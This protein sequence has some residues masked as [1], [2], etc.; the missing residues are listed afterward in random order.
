M[1]RAKLFLGGWVLA[2]GVL[3]NSEAMAQFGV[4][5]WYNPYGYGYGFGGGTVEG[6]ALMGMSTVIRSAGEYNLYT[7]EAGVNYEEARS[8]YLDNRRKWTQQ[9]FQMRETR[10]A[11]DAQKKE[12]ARQSRDAYYAASKSELSRAASPVALDPV[13]GHITWPEI[14]LADEF[15]K[16][17]KQVD[18]LF[19]LRAKTSQA[20]GSSLKIHAATEELSR[21]LR[22]RVAKI[23]ANEY[24]SARK[25]IDELDRT[26]R[27]RPT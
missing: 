15:K 27:A 13:T 6:N 2:L 11:I 7:A 17:R 14:L 26:V 16:P 8:K 10:S 18:E 19:E 9:Y 4:N 5:P 1:D 20:A 24:M 23:P 21:I 25:F 3:G 22:S 12:S